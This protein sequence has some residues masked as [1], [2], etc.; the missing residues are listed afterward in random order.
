MQTKREVFEWVKCVC[1]FFN[2]ESF[3]FGL[4]ALKTLDK[5]KVTV[6]ETLLFHPIFCFYVIH[7]DAH[8]LLAI[9]C[10]YVRY[11]IWLSELSTGAFFFHSESRFRFV[12]VVGAWQLKW[13]ISHAMVQRF[14]QH[15][16]IKGIRLDHVK[17]L[18]TCQ[19]KLDNQQIKAS[20]WDENDPAEATVAKNPFHIS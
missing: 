3:T 9:R 15:N 1:F 18:Y 20:I 14:T 13:D 16:L 17:F 19:Y 6:R 10:F 8:M 5:V 12:N 4:A 11:L 7:S 2:F